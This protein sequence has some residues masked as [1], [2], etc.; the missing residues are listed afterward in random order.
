MRFKIIS[1]VLVSAV[2]VL[3][4]H[5]QSTH[6]RSGTVKRHTTTT[7]KTTGTMPSG[8]WRNVYSDATVAVSMDPTATKQVQPGVYNARLRWQYSQD[9][10]IGRN[11]AYRT[12]VERKMIECPDLG[13]KAVSARTYDV[14]NKPVSAFD[15]PEAQ[16][17]AMD[18]AH[19]PAGTSA[20]KAYAALCQDIQKK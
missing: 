9:Q 1:A 16:V 4:L 8:A 18:W 7:R 12:L 6:A 15:T 17:R 14:A 13:V 3:P 2:V 11:H 20:A 19:R 10:Q 5:A